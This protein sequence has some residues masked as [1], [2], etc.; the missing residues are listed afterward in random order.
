MRVRAPR[1]DR[2]RGRDR[3]RRSIRPLSSRLCRRRRRGDGRRTSET[4]TPKWTREVAAVA[5]GLDVAAPPGVSRS[6][7]PVVCRQPPGPGWPPRVPL[8]ARARG[9][10]SGAGC[11][12]P[13][14]GPETAYP[15]SSIR[16]PSDRD[17]RPPPGIARAESRPFPAY[18]P[19]RRDDHHHCLRARRPLGPFLCARGERFAGSAGCS[20]G[21]GDRRRWQGEPARG[22]GAG[23]GT[24]A[25]RGRRPR[26][27]RPATGRGRRGG[28][29]AGRRGART[30]RSAGY[31]DAG[32]PVP[33]STRTST[34]KGSGG[35]A[36]SSAGWPLARRRPRS[37]RR[38]HSRHTSRRP[39][40]ASLRIPN[41]SSREVASTA[42]ATFRR[43][44]LGRLLRIRHA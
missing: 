10:P 22:T 11:P 28:V 14:A 35:D 13:G 30:R 8:P 41:A 16:H 42:V 4:T 12:L 29:R 24:R 1:P 26:T 32:G 44:G 7:V 15:W 27:R 43:W 33:A 25:P 9:V 31:Q 21:V 37:P 2:C 38:R 40:R 36:A 18:P 23:R 20:G 19:G 6:R 39:S 34:G 5:L 3:A 17:W